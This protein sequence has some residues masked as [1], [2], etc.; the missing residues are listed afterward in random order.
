M[1]IFNISEVYYFYNLLQPYYCFRSPCLLHELFM[2]FCFTS[3]S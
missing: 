3:L 1:K 2:I